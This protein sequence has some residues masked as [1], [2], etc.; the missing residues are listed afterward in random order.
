MFCVVIR[1]RREIRGLKCINSS[2]KLSKTRTKPHCRCQMQMQMKNDLCEKRSSSFE[3]SYASLCMQCECVFCLCIAWWV[4][5]MQWTE[6]IAQFFFELFFLLILPLLWN[7]LCSVC[8]VMYVNIMLAGQLCG[9]YNHHVMGACF[10]LLKW[11]CFVW[12]KVLHVALHC[13]T[14]WYDRVWHLNNYNYV[15]LFCKIMQVN[16]V[17]FVHNGSGISHLMGA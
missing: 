13:A 1:W 6:I 2:S 4:F 11:K 14:T 7:S 3:Q 8:L 10:S 16:G 9:K 17:H 15:I 12:D 5:E